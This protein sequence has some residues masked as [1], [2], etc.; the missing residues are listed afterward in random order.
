MAPPC[1]FPEKFAISGVIKTVIDS[2]CADQCI[3]FSIA[4]P[5]IV[6]DGYMLPDGADRVPGLAF[7]SAI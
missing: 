2:S 6:I 5:G 7:S 4:M 3:V 1:T